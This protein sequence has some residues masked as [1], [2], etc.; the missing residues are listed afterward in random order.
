[1]NLKNKDKFNL[2]TLTA[3]AVFKYFDVGI[4]KKAASFSN[5]AIFEALLSFSSKYYLLLKFYLKGNL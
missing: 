4:K 2:D 5:L 1:M 3:L